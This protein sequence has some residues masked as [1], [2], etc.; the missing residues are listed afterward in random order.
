[1]EIQNDEQLNKNLQSTGIM[2]NISILL[3]VVIFFRFERELFSF[4]NVNILTAALLKGFHKLS[5]IKGKICS[6][7]S[8]L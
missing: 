4:G 1:M 2:K 3:I 7:S 5:F 6:I 8:C